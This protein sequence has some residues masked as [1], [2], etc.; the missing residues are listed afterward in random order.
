MFCSFVRCICAGFRTAFDDAGS[1]G[2][3]VG[4]CGTI[5]AGFNAAAVG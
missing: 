4:C 5:V 1:I 2:I 3:A